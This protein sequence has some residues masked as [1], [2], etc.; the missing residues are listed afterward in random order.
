V[1][2]SPGRGED[3]PFPAGCADGGVLCL[4]LCV[5]PDPR[6]AASELARVIR[7]GGSLVFLE[8]CAAE[9]RGLR[10]VQR[11]ADATFW[12]LL[13][14]GCHTASDPLAAINGAGFLTATRR[15]RYARHPPVPS[16]PHALGR[17]SRSLRHGHHSCLS[18]APAA[19]AT[20]NSAASSADSH[21][22]LTQEARSAES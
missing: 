11:V 21:H 17:A 13:T 3:L 22:A 15:L 2:V 9:T 14:G 19:G 16:S 10:L 18:P 1:T 5:M 12:P 6:A 20:T 8:H 7:A 4:A